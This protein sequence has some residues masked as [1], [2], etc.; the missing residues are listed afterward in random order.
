VG[1]VYAMPGLC[2]LDSNKGLTAP[3]WSCSR[4]LAFKDEKD[5]SWKELRFK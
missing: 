3:T 4:A 2:W 5:E 1:D